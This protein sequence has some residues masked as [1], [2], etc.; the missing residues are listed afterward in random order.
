M[1]TGPT[2]ATGPTLSP[3][4]QQ[5]LQLVSDSIQKKPK[6]KEEALELMHALESQL[7]LT[8]IS[9]LPSEE[10]KV[11]LATKYVLEKVKNKCIPSWK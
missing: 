7:L 5:V 4:E 1:S 11:I 8:L 10:Q 2:G 9:D 3:F 6:S